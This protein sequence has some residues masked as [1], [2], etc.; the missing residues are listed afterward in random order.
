M[1][2]GGCASL[3]GKRSMSDH[4]LLAGAVLLNVAG[5]AWLALAMDVHW[6]QVCGS[7]KPSQGGRRLLRLT[8]GAAFLI[9]LLLCNLSDHATIAALVWVMALTAGAVIVAFTLTWRPAWLRPLSWL[10]GI[11]PTGRT[12]S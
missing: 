12:E 3:R 2:P 9:S 4:L 6:K 10:A 1:R 7:G 8:A 5:F 11:A